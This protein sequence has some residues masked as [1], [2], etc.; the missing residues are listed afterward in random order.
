[1]YKDAGAMQGA[2][3]RHFRRGRDRGWKVYATWGQESGGS[4][5]DW[6]CHCYLTGRWVYDMY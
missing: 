1:M 6:D 5:V 3:E 2:F 4:E